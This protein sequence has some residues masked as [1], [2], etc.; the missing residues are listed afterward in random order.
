M[1][2]TI[3]KITL[4]LAAGALLSTG[5]ASFKQDK[6]IT[7]VPVPYELVPDSANR[8]QM[9]VQLK[10]PGGYLSNRSRIVITPQLIT[11]DSIIDV[12]KA[13]AVYAPIYNKKVER[14]K[15]LENYVDPYGDSAVRLRKSSDSVDIPYTEEVILPA[16]V[17]NA[18]M[19][20]IV[21]ADGC[22][23]CTGMDTINIASFGTPLSL[24][25][26]A[27]DIRLSLL[28]SFQ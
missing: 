27:P 1:K 20:A 14:L 19:I 18:R 10:V 21:S 6:H 8:A 5:C 24:I 7:T 28:E 12:Y 26:F 11:G 4:S 2:H 13:I 16:D 25:G 17:E 9:D 15:V 22:G 3:N 23:V